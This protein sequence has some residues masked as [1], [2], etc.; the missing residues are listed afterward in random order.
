[1]SE[2][3]TIRGTT[4][5]RWDEMSKAQA[6][7]V[8]WQHAVCVHIAL[9]AAAYAGAAALLGAILLL[10]RSRAVD[11]TEPDRGATNS[12]TSAEKQVLFQNGGENSEKF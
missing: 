4:A 5:D 3:D 9:H 10:R 6:A 11:D 2:N 7:A 8:A 12:T 1:M